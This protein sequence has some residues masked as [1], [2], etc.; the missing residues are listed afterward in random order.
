V[1]SDLK[2]FSN[3]LSNSVDDLKSITGHLDRDTDVLE[4]YLTVLHVFFVDTKS[5][6][7]PGD[8]N[9]NNI[10]GHFVARFPDG[11]AALPGGHPGYSP[12]PEAGLVPGKPN[13]YTPI[14]AYVPGSPKH[15]AQNTGGN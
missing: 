4:T 3:E 1:V 15:N 6:F 2:P 14:P 9:G 5:V 8:A 10:R 7:G 12:G 11:P 13:A